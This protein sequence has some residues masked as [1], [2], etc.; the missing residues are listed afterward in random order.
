MLELSTA[1]EVDDLDS[2]QEVFVKT[3]LVQ[4]KLKVE[5][6]PKTTNHHRVGIS[7]DFLD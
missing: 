4:L 3:G 5:T 2:R 1:G 6:I 7:S